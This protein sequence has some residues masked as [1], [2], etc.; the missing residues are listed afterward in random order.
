M[1]SF[2]PRK[3][4]DAD[5]PSSAAS[6][7]AETGPVIDVA[8]A[9]MAL[10]RRRSGPQPHV[11]PIRLALARIEDAL[12]AIDAIRAA[13][14]EAGE[15]VAAADAARDPV[16]WAI[17]AERYD[18]LR[19]AVTEASGA[20]EKAPDC[21]TAHSRARLEVALDPFGRSRHVVRGMDLSAGVAGLDLPP[22]V[23]AFNAADERARVTAA[24]AAAHVKLDRATA[25]LLDD[26]AVLT[27]AANSGA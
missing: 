12:I 24:L 16:R 14:N 8:R 19:H 7:P 4:V 27:N 21:L 17:L 13:L 1:L 18:D 15:H 2:A 22:P 5:T 9:R 6:P 23:E 10:A 20:S 11:G 25:L 26:A 3:P